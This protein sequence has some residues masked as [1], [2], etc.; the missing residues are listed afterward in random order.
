MTSY[1]Y[2][3]HLNYQLADY[4]FGL[5]NYFLLGQDR[6]N[7][8]TYILLSSNNEPMRGRSRF[9]KNKDK[10]IIIHKTR[11]GGEMLNDTHMGALGG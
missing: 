11:A 2:P 1:H 10:E 5:G 6:E 8:V 9:P 3:I 7:E 4:V